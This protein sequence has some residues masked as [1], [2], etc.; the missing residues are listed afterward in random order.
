MQKITQLKNGG[1]V[2]TGWLFL[3]AIILVIPGC[4]K[5]APVALIQDFTQVNLVANNDEYAAARIDTTFING[6][7]IAFSGGGTAWVSAEGAG[8]STVWD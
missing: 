2:L 7:G 3:I 8:Y 1:F 4:K 5:N 6:W